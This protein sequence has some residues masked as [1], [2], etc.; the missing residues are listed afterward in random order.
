MKATVKNLRGS[1]EKLSPEESVEGGDT[2]LWGSV[3]FQGQ[4]RGFVAKGALTL[5][6]SAVWALEA[7]S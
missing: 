1:V 7:L 2:E 4:T 3:I 6:H 5:A